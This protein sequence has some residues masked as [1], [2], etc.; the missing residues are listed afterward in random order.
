MLVSSVM[1]ETFPRRWLTLNEEFMLPRASISYV[2]LDPYTSKIIE[3]LCSLKTKAQN[4]GGLGSIRD[5]IL[6]CNLS[7]SLGVAFVLGVLNGLIIMKIRL[8]QPLLAYKDQTC[9]NANEAH[10]CLFHY[11]HPLNLA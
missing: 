1:L 8:V 9:H 4:F 5:C 11:I 7:I 10:Y 2:A 3:R 6:S